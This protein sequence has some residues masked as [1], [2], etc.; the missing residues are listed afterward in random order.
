MTDSVFFVFQQN[1]LLTK[2]FEESSDRSVAIVSAAFLDEVLKRLLINFFLDN[3]DHD[4]RIFTGNGFLSTFSAK[5]NL[6]YRLGLISKHEYELIN[7]IRDIR[8]TFA[9][10]L[11][12]IS[13]KTQSITDKCKNLRLEK[14]L[15]PRINATISDENNQIIDF[16]QIIPESSN[17]KE[18]FKHCIIFLMHSLG[19]RHINSDKEKRTSPTDYK[20]FTEPFSILIEFIRKDLENVDAEFNKLMALFEKKL[21][22]NEISH[23]EYVEK[24]SAL[25]AGHEK[26]FD[27]FKI[28][29]SLLKALELRDINEASN[30]QN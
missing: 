14:N 3:D 27:F 2:E 30:L 4:K 5:I 1:E 26:V 24:T 12:D 6:S 7:K 25:K 29:H 19:T 18:I 11:S 28:Q 22:Q 20:T 9:H 21:S 10:Q 8:N 16:E 13:F 15:T 23:D 17:P